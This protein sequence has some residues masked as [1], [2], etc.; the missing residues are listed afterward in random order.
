[1]DFTLYRST[2]INFISGGLVVAD[3]PTLTKTR[4]YDPVTGALHADAAGNP[5]RVTSYFNLGEGVA[6]GIDASTRFYFTDHLAISSTM[7][8]SKLDTLKVKPTDPKDAGQFNA[9]SNRMS[10]SLDLTEVPKNL[11]VST[12]VRYT[13]AYTFRSGVAWGVV[14]SFGTF[15]LSASYKVPRHSTTFTIQGQNLAACFGGTFAPP[16]TG[17]SASSQGTYTKGRECGFGLR[18]LEALSMP[19]LGTMVFVGVRREWK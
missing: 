4:A 8:F 3:G 17:F 13:N 19:T 5:V 10:L 18:H 9:S 7:S 11:N 14:P 6:D 12:T 15:G 16:V 2:F 1:V